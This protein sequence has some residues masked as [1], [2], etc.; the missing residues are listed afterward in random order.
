M[1]AAGM[2]TGAAALEAL[3]AMQPAIVYKRMCINIIQIS[4]MSSLAMHG[5]MLRAVLELLLSIEE[6]IDYRRLHAAV[7]SPPV[8]SYQSCAFTLRWCD[9]ALTVAITALNPFGYVSKYI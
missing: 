8:S 6:I 3:D 9:Q 7:C 4:N 1:S 5:H 2:L